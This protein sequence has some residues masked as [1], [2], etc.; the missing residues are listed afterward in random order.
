MNSGVET[1]KRGHL[2]GVRGQRKE[3]VRQQTDH[4]R[5][6]TKDGQETEGGHRTGDR[7]TEE[8]V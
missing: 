8:K 2:I 6:G 3:E 1:Q 7:E 5:Q 4:V